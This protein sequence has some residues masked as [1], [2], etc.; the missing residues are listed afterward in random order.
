MLI[1]DGRR[2]S[3]EVVNGNGVQ[4]IKDVSRLWQYRNGGKPRE[5]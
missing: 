4:R 3:R 1:G 5:E 2:D